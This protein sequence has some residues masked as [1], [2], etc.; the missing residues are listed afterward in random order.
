MQL[1]YI[2]GLLLYVMNLR[3][4]MPCSSA[5]DLLT[6][7]NSDIVLK[8]LPKRSKETVSLCLGEKVM[9]ARD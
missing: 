9:S 1:H 7:A 5:Y 4:L 6:T 8:I 3:T 2:I